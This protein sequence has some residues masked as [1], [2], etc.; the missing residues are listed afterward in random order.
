MFS[1]IVPSYVI[2]VKHSHKFGCMALYPL[3]PLLLSVLQGTIGSRC[4]CLFSCARPGNS[5]GIVI[6]INRLLVNAGVKH[7]ELGTVELWLTID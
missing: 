5:A 1:T 6:I 4:G 7:I 2:Y 3:L